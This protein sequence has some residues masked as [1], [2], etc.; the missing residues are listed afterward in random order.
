MAN[1]GDAVVAPDQT[2]ATFWAQHVSTLRQGNVPAQKPLLESLSVFPEAKTNSSHARFATSSRM[3]TRIARTV[4][5]ESERLHIEF[6]RKSKQFG[7]AAVHTATR[8]ESRMNALHTIFKTEPACRTALRELSAEGL[9]WNLGHRR[10]LSDFHEEVSLLLFLPNKRIVSVLLPTVS[11]IVASMLNE[12]TEKINFRFV[13]IPQR[14]LFAV[15]VI[16]KHL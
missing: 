14:H 11:A 9:C 2:K 1:A 6:A 15:M 13:Y 12:T 3:V 8:R 16:T 10:R 7:T 4:R 5:A